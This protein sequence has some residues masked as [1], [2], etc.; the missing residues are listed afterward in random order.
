MPQFIY[1]AI[2]IVVVHK[3]CVHIHIALFL[4]WTTFFVC[5]QLLRFSHTNGLCNFLTWCPYSHSMDFTILYSRCA[6]GTRG[7]FFITFLHCKI[8]KKYPCVLLDIGNLC[9]AN[10]IIH[11]MADRRNIPQ[12]KRG[13]LYKFNINNSTQLK[14][15]IFVQI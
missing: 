4:R 1:Y 9:T 10:L 6:Y 15:E 14:R 11:Y 7:L 5:P 13:L 8:S 12:F 3:I 2:H